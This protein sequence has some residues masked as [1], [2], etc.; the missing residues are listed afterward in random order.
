M[1]DDQSTEKAVQPPP[2]LELAPN[3]SAN[4]N[5][6]HGLW[7]RMRALFSGA[8]D[9]SLRESLEDVIEQHGS[10][11]GDSGLKPEARSRMI[12]LLEFEDLRVD[13]VMVPRADII[14]VGEDVTIRELL[15]IFVE[16][17]HS[18]LPVFR[19][20]LDDPIGMVHVK[21]L[22]RWIADRGGTKRRKAAAKDGA[23][24]KTAKASPAMVLNDK[25]VAVT[26]GRARLVRELLFVPPSMPAGDLLIKMQAT[27]QH[28]A[29]V[30]D[31]YGGTD[32]LLTIE[33]LVE[34]IVGD[35]ADEHDDADEN[36]VHAGEGSTYIA[37]ARAAIE[38]VEKLLQVDLLPD[39]MDEDADTLGGFIF[40]MLG[41]VPTRGELIKHESGIEFE[42][43][44]ADPR[45]V[46][47]LKIHARGKPA[48]PS[49][50]RQ[51]DG[52]PS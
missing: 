44:G 16:A 31:E 14:A 30:V 45:R 13:D 25:D 29:I 34:E 47:K 39:D 12:N 2:D 8:Q 11:N 19:E 52:Q 38:D 17:N 22:M 7:S 28:M 51:V 40:F 9:A 36:L 6:P 33:D 32:G 43:L 4:G 37:D 48:Q 35:I 24:V 49:R 21:D 15:Q 50:K 20:T 3:T 42:I 26:I 5:R 10:E 46:R 27:R 1:D 23:D 18:R 41:R